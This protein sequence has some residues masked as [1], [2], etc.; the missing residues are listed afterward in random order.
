MLIVG[1][2]YYLCARLGLLLAFKPDYISAVWFPNAILL[3][4]LLLTP[5]RSWP[6]WILAAVPAEVAADMAS[7]ISP[8]LALKFVGV[9]AIEVLTAAVVIRWLAVFTPGYDRLRSLYIY[10]A[11]AVFLGPFIAAFPGALITGSDPAAPVFWVRWQRWFFSDSL[12]HLV[13]TPAII[14]W[15]I[16]PLYFRFPEKVGRFV[17]GTLLIVGLILASAHTF[18]LTAKGTL[19]H[20]WMLYL[21]FPLLL[22]LAVRFGARLT[23]SACLLFSAFAIWSSSHGT[24]P[25]T[26]LDPAANVL[27]LQFL[28]LLSL[29]SVIILA[30]ALEERKHSDEL[31]RSSLADK[32]ILLKEIH[33]R[34]KNNLQVISGLLDLQSNHIGDIAE[35]S[36]Y[37]ESQNRIITM[38]LI[39]EELY[40]SPDLARVQYVKYLQ[41]LVQNLAVSYGID[42][43][44][45]NLR[46]EADHEDLIIDTAIPCSLIVNELL[47]NSFRHAFPDRE[48]GDV[49]VAFKSLGGGLYEIE[50]ADDGVGLPQN[51][52]IRKV[53]SL[54]LKLVTLLVDQ[55]GGEFK[56]D[57]GKGTRFVVR[58]REYREAGAQL[59]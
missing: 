28:L 13:V 14:V 31:A 19:D 45:I 40:Q 56:V 51:M 2:A 9:D 8:I 17:E 53:D 49:L 5:A 48:N 41:N 35:K 59:Y 23:L 58:F 38:A 3:T 52:D 36:V 50:V 32:E 29:S 34:V 18:G 15:A 47:S 44:R 27:N 12:T 7:G 25:F 20:P 43:S 11:A 22:W 1:L 46:V 57:S 26:S 24:G 54:G 37:K 4:A 33:H 21:P 30:T 6:Y 16:R 55:L 10:F 39:H 42:R